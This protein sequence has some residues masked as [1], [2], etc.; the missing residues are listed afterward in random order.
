MNLK[1]EILGD[2]SKSHVQKIVRW[3]GSD[4]KRFTQLMELFLRGEYRVTQRAAWIISHCAELHPELIKPW[5]K[6]M[7]EKTKERGVHDAVP[8]NVL[9]IVLRTE[10]P[11]KLL[12]AVTTLCFD[13]LSIPASPIA[14]KAYA[15]T[16]L[17]KIVR[18]EP[19]L[20]N[21]L[22]AIIEQM[23]PHMG[24]ALKVRSREMMKGL[25]KMV[26]A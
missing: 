24:P 11:V 17:Q 14:V 22:L 13:L 16:I 26:S 10:I 1:T 12:G 20:K 7:I 25:K 18:R 15:M 4:K 19:E 8:R 9:R 5:L 23:L 21:E 2:H 3:I 6:R